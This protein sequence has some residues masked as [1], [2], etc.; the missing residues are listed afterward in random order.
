MFPYFNDEQGKKTLNDLGELIE[1]TN[2]TNE[3]FC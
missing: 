2:I 1:I 3:T